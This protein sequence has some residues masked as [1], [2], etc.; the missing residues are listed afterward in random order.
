MSDLTERA[1]LVTGA[2]RGIGRA[3]ALALADAGAAVAVNFRNRGQQAEEVC[4]EIEGAGGRALAVQADVRDADAV[5]A[6]VKQ[7]TEKLGGLHILVNNAGVIA[8]QYLMMM[9]PEQ[10]DDVVDT[11]LKG[12]FNCTKAAVRAMMR[13]RWGRIVNISSDAGLMGDVRRANYSAAKAGLVGFTKAVARELAGQGIT[14]NAVAPGIIETDMTADMEEARAQAFR[15]MIP[16][17]RFG[18]PQDVASVVTWLCSEAA[19]YITGQA[20][21]V[22]GGLRM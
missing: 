11:S 18:Q 4:A 3:T 5:T 9:K 22:D 14:V 13:G 16:L 7:V 12:A 21:S 10:W 8:D 15:E 17:G 2:S 1:A 20:I 6:M 19:G